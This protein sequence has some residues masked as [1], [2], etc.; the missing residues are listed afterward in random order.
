MVRES[1]G[2]CLSTSPVLPYRNFTAYPKNI[3]AGALWDEH[4]SKQTIIQ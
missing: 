4:N 2:V 1:T 3:L